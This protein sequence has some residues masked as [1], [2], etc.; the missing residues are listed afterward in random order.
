[1]SK[2]CLSIA[3][4]AV[5]GCI[6]TAGNPSR[7]AAQPAD[8]TRLPDFRKTTFLLEMKGARGIPRERLEEVQ[9]T[10]REFAAYQAQLI[11]HPLV[12][13]LM[14]DPLNRTD[15]SGRQIPTLDMI[16][17]D[18]E[19]FLVYP[20]P[21]SRVTMEQADYIREL[22]TALD[23]ALRP[24]ITSHPERIVRINATRMLAV[25]CKMGATAHY[26]TLTELISSPNVP[27][28]IKNY[29]L[30]AAANLLSAYDV[31]DYK[32]RRHSNGWRNNEK[33]GSADVE[34]A[35]LVGAI[36]KCITDPNTL[37]PGLWNGDMNKP[38]ILQPDQVEVAR[39][40]RRQAIRALAQVRFVTIS[41]AGPDGKGRLYPAY[42][43]ARVC[44][45]DPRL[46]L[47]PTPADCAEAVIGLC[48]MSPV[49]ED[50]KFV[51]EYNVDAA[52]EAIVAGLITFAE[53]RGDP[54]DTSLHWRVYGL[55][56]AEAMNNWP[57]LF[58]PLYDPTRPRQYN[59]SSVPRIV[60][61]LIQRARTTILD[62]LD[63]VGP[64]GKP[65]P[66]AGRV[67]LDTLREYLRQL[68]ANPKRNPIM[69]INNPET[70]LPVVARN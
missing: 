9:N 40:V 41:G 62:P 42:T 2:I 4:T 33:P 70:A 55:R 3:L 54:T 13:R 43:L 12:Y 44:L 18:L 66:L 16:F 30:Q 45:S 48:N 64:D 26:A 7:S 6:L 46:I 67:Q 27:T 49:L 51:K 37:V 29:A 34:L 58:D 47:P 11:S 38:A 65:D 39:F 53:P 17:R 10:F 36:E 35:A 69:F 32:S 60:D 24:L 22:G 14:R 28:E 68:R 52:V 25:V 59:K 19:R 61:D 15:A 57:P 23:A 20:A 8:P 1:M 63:R 31:L 50:G 21:G 56:I 5:L